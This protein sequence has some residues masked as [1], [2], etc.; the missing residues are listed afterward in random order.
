MFSV[1]NILCD[2][3]AGNEKLRYGHRSADRAPGDYAPRPVVVWAVTR[4]CN[5]KCVHCYA[6][7]D[8]SAAPNE[9]SFEEGC[10]LLD[11]LKAFGVPAVLFSGGEPLVR[12]D[13]L[14]LIAYARQIGLPCTLSTNGLL[15]DETVADRLAELGVKYVGISL[16]GI[17]KTHDKLRGQRGAFDETLEAIRRCQRHGLKVGVRFTVHRFNLDHLENIF[18]LCVREEID[19]L[20]VYHLA[21]AGRGGKMQLADLTPDQTRRAIDRLFELTQ[22]N[23]AQSAGGGKPLEALTVGNHADS[24]YAVLALEQIDPP[25][26]AAV[27]ERLSRTGGNRSGAN[28][29]SISPQG[30]VHYDQ[31]SWH[32]RVGNIRQQTFR[33]IWGN[34]PSDPRLRQ[35]RDRPTGLPQRCRGCRFL[36]LC[37]GNLRTRAESAT[38]DWLGVDPSCYLTEA[39]IGESTRCCGELLGSGGRQENWA[40]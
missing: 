29:C 9:L 25:R 1:S 20:C 12:P 5:L 24:A 37:N 34:T 27:A 35:L 13:T 14:E 19:R 30:D 7:A 16:D 8:A 23:H 2:H 33:D 6:N 18:D 28:I 40:R 38:G 4:A 15:I 17:G 3:A 21:Y 26:A 11:E 32:Y 22:L 36:G 39:E 10:R 31:F